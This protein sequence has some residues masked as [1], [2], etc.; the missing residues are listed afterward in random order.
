ME[1]IGQPEDHEVVL[2]NSPGVEPR[3]PGLSANDNFSTFRFKT[4]IE[5]VLK[6]SLVN[7]EKRTRSTRSETKDGK[8]PTIFMCFLHVLRLL[9]LFRVLRWP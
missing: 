8:K 9:R 5:K 3:V 7:N 6:D 2:S 4:E 1:G